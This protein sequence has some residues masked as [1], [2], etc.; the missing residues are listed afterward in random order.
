MICG[1][2]SVVFF[3]SADIQRLVG[4]P[5]LV[6]AFPW[7]ITLGAGVTFLISICFPTY[8]SV[9]LRSK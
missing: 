1:F 9:A 7:R 6:L 4:F 3:S 8:E 2:V 5:V